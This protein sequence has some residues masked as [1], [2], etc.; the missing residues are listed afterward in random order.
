[1]REWSPHTEEKISI[2]ADYLRALREQPSQH[3][4]ECISTRSPGTMN[5][6]KTTGEQFPGS[7][8]SAFSVEP[9][10]TQMLLF[11]RHQRRARSLRS[12][13]GARQST[14]VAVVEGDC[15]ET[16]AESLESVP[17]QAP[18]FAFLDPDGMELEWR[19]IRL[20]AN[21]KQGTGRNK[22]EM[23]VLLS[24]A[25]LVRMLGSNRDQA[26]QQRLPEKVA[27][28]YGA[29]GP[30]EAVW[31]ARLDGRIPPGDAKTCL[32]A[33][34]HGSLGRPRL[35][36]PPRSVNQERPQRA[37]RH[38]LR[39]RPPRRG[40]LK[41]PSPASWC[42]RSLTTSRLSSFSPASLRTTGRPPSPDGGSE[43]DRPQ[44]TRP[45]ALELLQRPA[46][47]RALLRRLRRAAH[48][49]AVPEDGRRADAGRRS[50]AHRSCPTD[51]T[52]SPCSIET[53]TSSKP[54][55]SRS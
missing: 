10:F 19:T 49:P 4:I 45:E 14:N 44:G 51:S 34:L 33:A 39:H 21:H 30:W 26:E 16:M 55:T 46:R 5:V 52:G 32:S 22:V 3:R 48:L 7:V 31:N 41:A 43:H 35:Q 18:A 42:H 24:T 13:A 11:E 27:R 47:R 20:V 2:L 12:L 37:V 1:M 54:T 15:N 40:D 36:A 8:E 38:G 29:R 9:A 23:W 25:G 53:A 50:T 6:L 17:R 28:L